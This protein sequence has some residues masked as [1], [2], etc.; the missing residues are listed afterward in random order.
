MECVAALLALGLNQDLYGSGVALSDGKSLLYANNEERFSR[1]KNQGG[2]PHLS[3]E[4]LFAYTGVSPRDVT[5]IAVCGVM[6]PP[7]PLRVFPNVQLWLNE[8]QT[9]RSTTLVRRLADATIQYTPIAH[10]SPESLGFRAVRRVL[11]AVVRR[12]LPASLR[13]ARIHLAEHHRAHAACAFVLSGFEDALCL[14]SDGM[15]DGVSLSISHG[16][17]NAVDRLYWASSRDSFGL[18]FETLT[19]A[20]GFIPCRDEG[21]VTGLAAHGDPRAVA[22]PS[23]FTVVEGRSHYEGPRGLAA[24]QAFRGTLLAQHRQEDVAAWAQALLDEHLVA[25]ARH[26]LRETGLRRLVLGGGTVGNVK[27]NQRLHEMPE[28]DEVFVAPNMGDGGNPVGALAATGL[29]RPHRLADVFLGED[30]SDTAIEDALRKA[31]LRGERPADIHD[32]MGG[33]LAAGHTVARFTGRMEWGPRALGNRSILA[34]ANDAALV[35]RLNNQ[36]RRT[37]FM[38]FAPA[39]SEEDIDRFLL[40]Y[41]A[42]LYA[43]EFMTVCF[44]CSDAMRAAFP[45]VVHVDGTARAQVV[46][47]ANN[48]DFHAAL[49]AYKRRSGAAVLLNTSYNIHE[50]PIVRTPDEAIRAFQTAKLDC[51][52][53]G[54][55]LVAAPHLEP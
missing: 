55:Y 30:Y 34:A 20:M 1:K 19:E 18:F 45:A 50:E 43:G 11:P 9:Q 13:H 51:L 27:T 40:Q 5:D 8:S 53:I 36:L 42:G 37:D 47:A 14:T 22:L 38:P 44:Q 32:A 4:G 6:T 17:G 52:A 23:P 10:G 21:K 31:G 7:L 33:L 49:Q 26:W 41:G 46:R 48:P 54:P 15:G 35:E 3:L 28:V 12:L 16:H 2:F 39:I 29:L 25:I 24:V